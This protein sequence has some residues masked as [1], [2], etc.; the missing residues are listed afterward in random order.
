MT[1]PVP[2]TREEAE[3]AAMGRECV[4][5]LHQVLDVDEP[6]R[7]GSIVFRHIKTVDGHAI[8]LSLE[9]LGFEGPDTLPTIPQRLQAG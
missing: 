9:Y 5:M 2:T 4:G 3:S 1:D 7:T 6:R 8:L